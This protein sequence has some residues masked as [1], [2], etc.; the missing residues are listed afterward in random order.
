MHRTFVA[1]AL[2][3]CACQPSAANGDGSGPSPRP[4]QP[5]VTAPATIGAASAPAATSVGPPASAKHVAGPGRVTPARLHSDALGV[6]KAAMVWTPASYDVAPARRYPVV[7]L[8]HGLGGDETNWITHGKLP[9]AA[10]K[11]GLEAI[12][13]MI[14]GDDGFYVD[15]ARP[16]DYAACLASQPPFH[17]SE[18]PAAYCVKSSRYETYVVRDVVGWVDRTLRT[19]PE[20]RAR[21]ITGLSMGGFGALMLAMRHKDV[22]ASAASHSGLVAPLYVGPHPYDKARLALATASPGWGAD[23]QPPVRAQITSV[24]G[25]SFEAWRAWDPATLAKG[26][27][28]GE[29]ALFIDCGTEDGFKFHDQA[30]YLH[31]ALTDAGIPHAFELVKGDHTFT[32]WKDRIGPSLAFHA[33]RFAA[34]GL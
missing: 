15:S 22:F 4:T 29:L 13:V 7:Y 28:P 21:A 20:R 32:L 31:D 2:L 9:E 26:L 11:L 33:A 18:S 27:E 10:E 19:V 5:V 30:R 34:A 1:A 14:D 23:Y 3:S 12:V 25:S 6:D 16:V 17:R 24:L 8:L